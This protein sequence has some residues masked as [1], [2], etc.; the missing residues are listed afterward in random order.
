MSPLNKPL[1]PT[2]WWI[3]LNFIR[4]RWHWSY[5]LQ[6]ANFTSWYPGEPDNGVTGD[7]AYLEF[8]YDYKWAD[9]KSYKMYPICQFFPI[10]RY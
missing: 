5:S 2:N 10:N 1:F 8:S 9:M 6:V 7:Y 3:G 4:G